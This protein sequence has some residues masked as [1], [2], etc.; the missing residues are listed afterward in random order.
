MLKDITLL[1]LCAAKLQQCWPR[2]HPTPWAERQVRALNCSG[3]VPHLL[4]GYVFAGIPGDLTQYLMCAHVGE[5]GRDT[6]TQACHGASQ[7]GHSLSLVLL[8][9]RSLKETTWRRPGL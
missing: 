9:P 2:S 3:F 6:G 7:G 5:A 8:S 4:R 1:A